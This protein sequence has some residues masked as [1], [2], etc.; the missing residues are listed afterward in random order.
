MLKTF[1]I[2]RFS[3]PCARKR[4]EISEYFSS[5]KLKKFSVILRC[6]QITKSQSEDA[7]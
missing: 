3:V 5:I 7:T 2:S 4:R 1:V 6:K